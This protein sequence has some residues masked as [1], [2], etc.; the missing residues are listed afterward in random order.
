MTT[1]NSPA[2]P[3][4]P[5]LL[6]QP[7]KSTL[8]LKVGVIAIFAFVI[9]MEFLAKHSPEL[10]RQVYDLAEAAKSELKKDCLLG[11]GPAAAEAVGIAAIPPEPPPP[12]PFGPAKEPGAAERVVHSVL[13]AAQAALAAGWLSPLLLVT[14][15]TLGICS[16]SVTAERLTRPLVAADGWFS[17][18]MIAFGVLAVVLALLWWLALHEALFLAACAGGGLAVLAANFAAVILGCFYLKVLREKMQRRVEFLDQGPGSGGGCRAGNPG[19]GS[20]KDDL[21]ASHS[22][23]CP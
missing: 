22:V 4:Q 21:V 7:G 1:Q 5:A 19:I 3:E 12:A 2:A 18:P 17:A 8:A 15:V 14:A 11:V 10:R 16:A 13:E 6:P 23:S 20:Q 9:V